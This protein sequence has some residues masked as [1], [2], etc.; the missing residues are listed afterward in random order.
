MPLPHTT[1]I[2]KTNTTPS[3]FFFCFFLSHIFFTFCLLYVSLI[4]IFLHTLLHFVF[5][6][7]STPLGQKSFD[8]SKLL[9]HQRGESEKDQNEKQRHLGKPKENEEQKERERGSRR[10]LIKDWIKAKQTKGRY[11]IREDFSIFQCFF[12]LHFEES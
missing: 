6:Q 10:S 12:V 9:H 5:F 4:S 7:V 3:F 8:T 1:R 2:T 11:C